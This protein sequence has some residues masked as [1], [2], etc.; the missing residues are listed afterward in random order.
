MGVVHPTFTPVPPPPWNGL[1][2]RLLGRA[3]EIADGDPAGAAVL[4]ALVEA[5]WEDQEEWNASLRQELRVH[6]EINNALVGISGNAQLLLHSPIAQQP[7]TRERLEVVLRESTR[8][9]QAA[10]RLRALKAVF[11]QDA[12]GGPHAIARPA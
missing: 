6:H 11:D 12:S 2:E 9:E 4:R 8:I 1:R 10:R 3:D 5:W 7:A